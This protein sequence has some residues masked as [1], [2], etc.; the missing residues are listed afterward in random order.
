MA[1][2][3]N[4]F[5]LTVY[6]GKMPIAPAMRETLVDA[7]L[8]MGNA[9]ADRAEGMAWTGDTRGHGFL[10]RDPR[11]AELFKGLAAHLAGY[12]ELLKIAPDKL[13]LYYTRSW[14]TISLGEEEI[15]PHT[16][17]QSHLSL[18]YYLKKPANSGGIAFLDRASANEFAPKLFHEDMFRQGIVSQPTAFNSP[19]I[20]VDPEEDD[21]LVFPSKAEHKTQPNRSGEARISIAIDIVATARDASLLEFLLPDL[22]KWSRA[23]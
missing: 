21:V 15:L 23:V 2:F 20:N 4:A 19:Q 9:T 7:V 11:F 16:H 12:L 14:P 1:E 10:H 8:E 5:P 18:V 6:R 17:A 3:I 22:D 13:Y